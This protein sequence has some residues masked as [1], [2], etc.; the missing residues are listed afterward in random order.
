[1]STWV[2]T[3]CHR[4]RLDELRDMLCS[5]DHDPAHVVVVTTLPDP[6][7]GDDVAERADHV[8]VFEKPGMLFGEWFNLGFDYI[9]SH[10]TDE[11]SEVVCIGS[12]LRGDPET[13]PALRTALRLNDLSMVGPDMFSRMRAGETIV[14]YVT[15]RRTLENRVLANCFM[16]AGELGLRFDPEFRWWYSDDDLEMQA[17]HIK[18]VGNVGGVR[19]VMTHPDGH[20]LSEQQAIWA[21]EDRVKF[22]TKWGREPW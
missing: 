12:S 22:V 10:E 7:E 2:V 8:V 17:R 5:L 11:K 18:P 20:Y 4:G 16:V 6:I 14:E 19:C 15:D 1:M 9:A 13:I 21:A 3:P